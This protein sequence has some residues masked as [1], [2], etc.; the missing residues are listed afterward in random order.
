MTLEVFSDLVD[1]GLD[2]IE[3]NHVDHDA[4]ARRE[5]AGIA[6]ELGLVITGS[7][8]YH[9]TGK[10]ADFHLGANTTDPDQFEKLL[11]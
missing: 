10:S 4:E 2:G 1:L 7:S 3:V 5:L 6:N 11:G 9:G 8:D